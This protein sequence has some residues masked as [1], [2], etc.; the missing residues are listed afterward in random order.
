M[1]SKG[2]EMR[3]LVLIAAVPLILAVPDI[4]A[5]FD[6]E[7]VD[8]EN[9]VE[10]VRADVEYFSSDQLE[11][12]GIDT[13]GIKLAAERIIEEYKTLGLKP[14]MPDGSYLQPFPVTVGQM[15]TK[16]TTQ[17]VL[18]GP[19]G[20]SRSLTV[21]SQFQPIRRGTNGSADGDLVFIGYGIT[22]EDDKY[23]DYAEVDVEGKVVVMIRREPRQDRDDGGFNGKE[24]SPNA[25]I[26][27]KLEL[28]V[29]NKAAAIIFVNDRFTHNSAER[30][31][32]SPSTA[33]GNAGD[34]IPFVHVKQSV[35]DDLLKES[36]LKTGDQTLSSLDEVTAFIDESLTPVSQVMT[37]WSAD[38][39]TE[40]EVN[41]VIAENIIGVIEGEGPLSDETIV[42]GGHYDHLGY[43]GFGSRARNRT[44]EIHN[45]ADDNA[46]GTAAVLELARRITSGPKPKRRIVFIC[47]SA[48]ERG[49]IGS[50]YY[51]R[52]PVFALDNTVTMLNFD[53]IGNLRN[54]RVEVN[55]VGTASEFRSI[56]ESTD[57]AQPI[58]ITIKNDPFGGSDHL[59]FYQRKIPVMFCFT[60]MTA[61]YHTPDDDFDTLNIEGTVAVI[62]YAEGLFRGIDALETRPTFTAV[63][64]RSRRPSGRRMPS[65]GFAPELS[66][67]SGE[68]VLVRTVRPDS[69][70][71]K[72]GVQVGDIV[73]MIGEKKVEGFQQIIETLTASKVGDKLKLTLKRGDETVETTVELGAPRR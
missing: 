29:Q 43:G 4:A 52:H 18:N 14:A 12:R 40:F 53:M 9:I 38:I 73:T 22:S 37:G 39:T 61:I 2:T 17:V 19:D 20:E 35:V 47:F 27:R 33:F 6:G 41:T 44:G 15:K 68:G 67:Y 1:L 69:P 62:D 23:D 56:V 60:G 30:D 58:D 45:G 46:T 8:R 64:R 48:E 34:T 25:Y 59:P 57:E 26:D 36:P 31:E 24:T 49:L 72:A 16:D 32:L 11:G 50:N 63:A 7:D 55:G 70:A 65:L 51:V 13:K 3:R 10:R 54:N 66:D 21:E 28:A 42:I 5:A 71:E